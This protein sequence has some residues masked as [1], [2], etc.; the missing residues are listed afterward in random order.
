LHRDVRGLTGPLAIALARRMCDRGNLEYK[1]KDVAKAIAT[2]IHN[3]HLPA[4]SMHKNMIHSLIEQG[5][6]TINY[7]AA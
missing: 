1:A 4:E 3:K 2:G 5:A 7:K 6:V